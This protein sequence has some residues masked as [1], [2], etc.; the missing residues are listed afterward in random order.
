MSGVRLLTAAD[1][2]QAMLLKQSAGW[3]QTEQDWLRLLELEPEGCFGIEREGT[4]VATTTAVCYGRELAWIGM[5]LTLAECR[6]QGLAS[7][8]MRAA[9]EF[10]DGREIEWVKLDATAMGRGLYRKFGFVE[11]CAV[12]RWLRAP[13][14]V[15]AGQVAAYEPDAELDL[16]AFGVD[17]SRVLAIL[18]DESASVHGAGFAMGRAGSNAAFFGPCVALD[19]AAAARLVG[20]FLARHGEEP[21]YW[22]LAPEH[23]EAVE[24]AQSFG[25]A[26]ARELVRM[27]RQG[28]RAARPAPADARII[29]AMAGF[30]F[31]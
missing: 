20:W 29:Y 9:L 27:A 3:N 14:A 1:V 7:E 11:E 17:R 19:A 28:V 22:D 21:A 6:G 25:F 23:R 10:L 31:G 30:E 16:R 12:E 13:G 24:L 2:P 4:L 5:V 18:A 15:E 8:L 26:R